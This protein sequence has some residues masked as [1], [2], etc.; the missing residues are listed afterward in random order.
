MVAFSL[1]VLYILL[2]SSWKRPDSGA[3]TDRQVWLLTSH[4]RWRKARCREGPK[5]GLHLAKI[6]PVAR[7]DA[8]Q[9][10]GADWV[11]DGDSGVRAAK[12]GSDFPRSPRPCKIPWL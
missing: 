1:L 9:L 5:E 8:K 6:G 12:P 2:A 11:V 7:W 3:L 10:G 4:S